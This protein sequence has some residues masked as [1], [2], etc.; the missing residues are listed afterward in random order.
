M[1]IN[2]AMGVVASMVGY[3]MDAHLSLVYIYMIMAE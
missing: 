2:E 1:L 3:T